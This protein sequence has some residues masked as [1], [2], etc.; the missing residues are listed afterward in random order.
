MLLTREPKTPNEEGSFNKARRLRRG[1]TLTIHDRNKPEAAQGAK[2]RQLVDDGT[3]SLLAP[4]GRLA[5][6]DTKNTDSKWK[7]R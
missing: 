7:N 4:L 3:G 6:C 1:L 2:T 5:G